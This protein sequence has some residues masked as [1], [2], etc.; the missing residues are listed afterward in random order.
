MLNE[1]EKSQKSISISKLSARDGKWNT[2]LLQLWV[3][4][5]ISWPEAELLVPSR[6]RY[7][8]Y[9]IEPM[10]TSVLLSSEGNYFLWEGKERKK[11]SVKAQIF[12]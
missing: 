1:K 10:R 7:Y 5:W 4:T 9:N 2:N 12:S 11:N 3:I 6:M 8:C